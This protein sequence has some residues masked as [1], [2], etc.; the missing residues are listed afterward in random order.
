MGSPSAKQEVQDS[1]RHSY[2]ETGEKAT[3][4][5]NN[6]TNECDTGIRKKKKDAV[7]IDRET[8]VTNH[9][10]VQFQPRRS[11]IPSE[12]NA[13]FPYFP[14]NYSFP[15][16]A[17]I[18]ERPH[19]YSTYGYP[20]PE[21]YYLYPPRHSLPRPPPTIFRYK[22]TSEMAPFDDASN[23]K[24]K[25]PGKGILTVKT[26][27]D[28]TQAKH[29]QQNDS[30]PRR[31]P[32]V[33]PPQGTSF[34]Y[35]GLSGHPHYTFHDASREYDYSVSTAPTPQRSNQSS[36]VTGRSTSFDGLEQGRYSPVTPLSKRPK[37]M[38]KK[39]SDSRMD[40][41]FPQDYPFPTHPP[42]YFN[43]GWHQE[44]E[45]PHQPYYPPPY[46]Q[47]YFSPSPPPPPPPY[48]DH[49]HQGYPSY[50]TAPAIPSPSS[51]TWYEV[52]RGG[53]DYSRRGAPGPHYPYPSSTY[54]GYYSEVN[55]PTT[56]SPTTTQEFNQTVPK[57]PAP[58]SSANVVPKVTPLPEPLKISLS[59]SSKTIV[60]PADNQ[61]KPTA[62][63]FKSS[64]PFVGLREIDIVCGRGAPTNFHAGNEN[65]RN[66]VSEYITAYFC[67]KRSDKPQIAMK[68]LDALQTQGSRFV[69]RV[70]GGKGLSSYWEEVPHKVAYEKVCQAL[71]D[72][73]PSMQ[74][75]FL[76]TSSSQ[77][78]K[79]SKNAQDHSLVAIILP[80]SFSMGG[81]KGGI[82]QGDDRGKENGNAA[83]L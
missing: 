24:Q 48:P 30:P 14:L 64:S 53:D 31:R 22:K 1:N 75:K 68:V 69:R 13:P 50:D 7:N 2:Y 82:Q 20:R 80:P 18:H 79:S 35:N 36:A 19:L 58:E 63:T 73:A 10:D 62:S 17:P 52:E 9:V 4:T 42:H 71:R 3:S 65:F 81:S 28:K 33:Q 40:H 57:T 5:I 8:S 12:R 43:N 70:K 37:T 11:G 41:S 66:L 78:K 39:A 61:K 34:L 60:T 54:G 16:Y 38:N 6:G 32:Q 83:V 55:H 46:D 77:Q 74:R 59:S 29:K 45:Y 67:A 15:Q 49:Y 27:Q 76:S 56:E 23:T 47:H 51:Q 26:S 25:K 72:G 21:S 44:H